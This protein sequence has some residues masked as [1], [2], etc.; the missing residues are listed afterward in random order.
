M[1]CAAPVIRCSSAYRA[2]AIR[3]SKATIV[4]EWLLLA[5]TVVGTALRV[6]RSVE[7]RRLLALL[8]GAVIGYVAAVLLAP[9]LFLPSRHVSYPVPVLMMFLLPLAGR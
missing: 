8:A 7:L 1:R 2:S 6:S 3:D 4:L 9:N 5:V